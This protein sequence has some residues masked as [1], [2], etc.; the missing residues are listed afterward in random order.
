LINQTG[1][2]QPALFALEYAL[3]TLWRS[4]GVRPDFVIGH[5][6]G[7]ISA[8]CVA[9]GLALADALRLIAARGR[10]MQALPPGGTM[11]SVMTTESRVRDAIAGLEDTV[12]I[13]A[14]NGPSQVVISG[15][16]TQVT[17]VVK[18]LAVDGVKSKELI[19]SH[20]FHSPLMRP[21][22]TE[23]AAVVA[24]LTFRSPQIPFVSGIT[25]TVA[26]DE[27]TRPDYWLRNVTDPVR[28]DAGARALR[29]AGVSSFVEIGPQ[30]I[31]LGMVRQSV[32]DGSD[33][34]RWIAS[35]RKD[36]PAVQTMMNAAAQAYESG[37]DLA[38]RK[39]AHGTRTQLP[40]YP[41][42]RKRYWI[43]QRA[44]RATAGGELRPAPAGSTPL[45][46]RYELE[47]VPQP[48]PLH[49]ASRG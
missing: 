15:P 48:L 43:S 39:L 18:T 30:P 1:Y 9:E 31:L 46:E 38:W 44:Q 20:A 2:T 41:F 4:W 22:L 26:G 37:V 29:Q 34:C 8:M 6:V 17:G 12:A 27:I 24:S 49:D 36:V 3:A 25:G 11:A 14:I 45:P 13:A 21:M 28:F 23:Y 35:L 19:V 5:S 42:A 16:R 33:E 10:L 40:R 7:E 47:W 32:H